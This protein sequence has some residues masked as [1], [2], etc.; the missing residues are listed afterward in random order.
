MLHAEG[1]E[2][3]WRGVKLKS[4]ANLPEWLSINDYF[5]NGVGRIGP[6]HPENY[7]YIILS[8]SERTENR[9]VEKMIDA[10]QLL[11]GLLNLYSTWGSYN[12]TSS[13]HWTEGRFL[14]GPN[15]FVFQGTTFCGADRIWYNPDYDELVWGNF[16]ARMSEVME[17]IPNIGEAF[18]ALNEHP[19]RDVLIPTLS[20]MQDGFAARDPNLRL[21]RYWSALERLYVEADARNGSNEKVIRRASFA[22]PEPELSRWKLEHIARSRNDYVHAGSADADLHHMCQFLR[23][24]LGRHVVHWM[25]RGGD[26]ADHRQL[27]QLVTLPSDRSALEEMKQL[28]NRRLTYYAAPT[29]ADI[30]S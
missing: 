7:G 26:I 17:I 16:P 23:Q 19:L 22:E 11:L 27:L 8:C 15:H 24:L 12:W 4:A 9:A 1:F 29:A 6:H 18:N 13:R 5:L 10:L 20:L 21:L 2:F 3:Q 28:I 30:S 14:Q 25:F